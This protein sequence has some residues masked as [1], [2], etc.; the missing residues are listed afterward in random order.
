M[1]AVTTE[2]PTTGR[3]GPAVLMR[4]V[5]L[6]DAPGVAWTSALAQ[7][8]PAWRSRRATLAVAAIAVPFW[9]V[10]TLVLP[11][12]YHQDR[13]VVMRMHR[14]GRAYELRAA[15]RAACAGA[16]AIAALAVVASPVLAGAWHVAVLDTVAAVGLV[17]VT[18]TVV[19]SIALVIPPLVASTRIERAAALAGTPQQRADDRREMRASEW[20]IE[21]AA[22]REPHGGLA[23]IAEHVRAVVGAG[24]TV[25]VRAGSQKL[26]DVYRR[27]YGLVPFATAPWTFRGSSA[28]G[29]R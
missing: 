19:P 14:R 29:F 22:S 26:A 13:R 10:M 3:H 20:V 6:R 15:G 25:V 5:R 23:A 7:R 4:R 16:L 1:C 24:E 9:C 28:A 8:P 11:D 17:M 2:S 21:A 27:R 12:V 18:I